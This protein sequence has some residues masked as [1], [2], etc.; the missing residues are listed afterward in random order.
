MFIEPLNNSVFTSRLV[1][2]GVVLGA[3]LC[4]HLL[5]QAE[6]NKVANQL[7][8]SEMER[9]S[10]D[11]QNRQMSGELSAMVQKAH[12]ND[13][14][15]AALQQSL[16]DLRV[17][18]IREREE[19]QMFRNLASGG[20][21]ITGIAVEDV[22]ITALGSSNNYGL[23][24]RLTQP[25]GRKRVAG[26]L[27]IMIV[28]ENAAGLAQSI[29]LQDIQYTDLQRQKALALAESADTGSEPGEYPAFDF[30]YYQ[31]F[32]TSLSL[33]DGFTPELL[34]IVANP[35]NPYRSTLKKVSLTVPWAISHSDNLVSLTN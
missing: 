20:E 11:T 32:Q 22:S 30:R 19:L 33:P 7:L 31:N 35:V 12:S 23:D 9:N 4:G 18:R 8:L 13:E 24:L 25:R 15:V 10:L 5:G 17:Q 21:N 1:K 34:K 27:S 16:S 29:P 6:Y 3:F 2:F 14:A 28:G 26:A